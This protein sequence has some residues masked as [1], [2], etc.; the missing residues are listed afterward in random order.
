[1]FTTLVLL[2]EA[3]RQAPD[4]FRVMNTGFTQMIGSRWAR[5]A[6]DRGDDPREIARRWEEENR[7]WI[8][9]KQDRYRLYPRS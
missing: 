1:V 4:R 3:K 6:F 2:T 9:T 5:E 7:T 8:S